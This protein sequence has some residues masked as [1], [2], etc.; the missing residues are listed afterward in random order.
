MTV[1]LCQV[2]RGPA[3]DCSRRSNSHAGED[4]QRLLLR[5]Q[6]PGNL[7]E[8]ELQEDGVTDC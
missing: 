1:H 5:E 8:T 7:V 4:G 3:L 2:P 6:C